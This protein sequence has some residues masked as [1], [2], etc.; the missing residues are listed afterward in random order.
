MY[1]V[2]S[3]LLWLTLAANPG[4]SPAPQQQQQ[5]GQNQIITAEMTPAELQENPILSSD[6][7]VARQALDK[8]IA[9]RDEVTL[10]LGLKKSNASFAKEIVQAVKNAYY[11]SFVPDL[12]AMLEELRVSPGDDKGLTA[13]KREVEKAIVSALMHLT[14]LR[15]SVTENLSADDVQKTAEQS[16]LWYAA[17]EAEIQKSLKDEML[18]RQQ[19]TPILSKNYKVAKSAFD[20]A[21][22]EKDKPTL[23]LG[24]QK[25]SLTLK[26]LI[27][28]AIRQFDD[29]SFVPDL[30]KALEDNQSIMSGG[31]ETQAAQQELNKEIIS[32]LKQLTGLQ[33]P[34][35]TD[36][37]TVPCF[38]DCPPK[39]IQK[40]LKDSREWWSV[41]KKDFENTEAN[42]KRQ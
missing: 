38:S 23:R 8:A 5:S 35:L 15:F 37:S 16:R 31:S 34:Y 2:I 6:Y 33:F 25:N 4:D 40:V 27:V 12:T 39:D 30:I 11:Q 26:L 3:V 41:N 9:E 24:L 7:A 1:D 18:D 22:A 13:E 19:T 21:V 36:E 20:K 29:K 10:R 42:S 17:N 32:D 28:Q 14:G